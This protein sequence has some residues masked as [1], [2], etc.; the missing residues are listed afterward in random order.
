MKYY[1]ALLLQEHQNFGFLI[2]PFIISNEGK[3]FYNI[4]E[5]LFADRI[6]AFDHLFDDSHRKIIQTIETYTDANLA[7]R[8]S[9]KKLNSRDFL[10]KLDSDYTAKFIRPF[11]ERQLVKVIDLARTRKVNL[12]RRDELNVIYKNQ[13]IK[14]EEEPAEVVFNFQ[15]FADH[16]RYFQTIIHQNT[17]IVPLNKNGMIL[18][19]DPCLLLLDNKLYQFRQDVDGKKLSVFFDKEYIIVPE[20]HEKKYYSTFIKKCIRDFT[21]VNEGF[22]IK[23]TIKKMHPVISLEDDLEGLPALILTFDYDGQIVLPGAK[24]TKQ[25]KLT[26]EN[27]NFRYE[28]FERDSLGEEEAAQLLLKLGLK[29]FYENIYRL[30]NDE[31]RYNLINW[32]NENNDTLEKNGFHLVQKFSDAKYFTENLSADVK[33]EQ[34]RDWF[35]VNAVVHFGND[36]SIP[37]YELRHHILNNIREFR[38]PDGRVA[39]LPG[40]WFTRYS[41]MVTFGKKAKECIR[42]ENMHSELVKNSINQIVSVSRR[43]ADFGKPLIKI[44]H[45]EIPKQIKA[46]LRNYQQDGFHWMATLRERNLGGCLADDMGLGKTLQT[47]TII[48]LH[49]DLIKKSDEQ[50]DAKLSDGGQMDLFASL[51]T[52]SI[53]GNPS[54]VIMPASLIHNWQNEIRKFA[55]HLTHI[56]YTG[57]ARKDLM[58]FFPKVNL[59]LTTYGTVRNDFE[60]LEKYQFDYI[61]LDESHVIKNPLSKTARAIYRLDAKHRLALSGT[62][63]ENSLTDLWSQMHFLNPGLLRDLKFFKSYFAYPIE[64]NNDEDKK[65]KLLLLIKPFILRRTK[66][67]VEKELPELSEEFVYCEMTPEQEKYYNEEKIRVRNYI[68]D[69]IE[70]MGIDKSAIVLLQAL[71][72]LRQIAS[73]PFMIDEN[74]QADS[75]KFNEVVRNLETLISEGHKILVFSSFVKHL[76]IF[77][78]WFDQQKIKY[79]LLTGESKNRERIIKEFQ[80]EADRNVFFISLKA[81]GTG[82]NLTEAGYVFML[83]P[84]WNPQ[85]ENQAVNRAHRIGQTKHVFVYRFISMGT[86]EEKIIK[87]Q[88]KKSLLAELFIKTDNPLSA[89]DSDQIKILME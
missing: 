20:K 43:K 36:Y 27:G 44:N 51:P 39:I 87:L 63:I 55:P 76:K 81:G 64:K 54:L 7:V 40:Q 24:K 53:T 3:N 58:A 2:Y 26:E 25:V 57:A 86:L 52:E 13:W 21:V 68:F 88:Q 15:K 65:Q 29:K 34:K 67:Q 16:T 47:L 38:L 19:N 30:S 60:D 59:I 71:T 33:F 74:Y 11:I 14:F 23:N 85:V 45:P 37:F 18:T 56:N 17:T 83:D 32:L 31:N 70:K 72:K 28:V 73:H 4:E 84:W 79:A 82:L 12:Y 9:S 77:T 49:L 35:D 10:K 62:P 41:D 46:N 66:K 61:I 8:F 80:N 50:H 1:F 42:I 48:A 5:R 6:E 89:M 78:A 22:E 75:G 69:S